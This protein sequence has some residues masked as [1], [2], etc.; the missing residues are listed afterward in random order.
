MQAYAIAIE[1]N[2]TAAGRLRRIDPDIRGPKSRGKEK[3]KEGEEE[4]NP[5]PT[6]PKILL[7][8]EYKRCP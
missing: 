6:F 5:S 2:L 1:G 4:K 7:K 3:E 8:T